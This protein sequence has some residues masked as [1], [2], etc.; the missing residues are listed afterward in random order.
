MG[1]TMRRRVAVAPARVLS[2][3]TDAFALVMLV[4]VLIVGIYALWDSH[5]VYSGASAAQWLPYRPIDG[6]TTSYD[7]L[8]GIN[9][10]V[11]GWLN[12]Y[13]T[14][15]DY[16]VCQSKTKALKYVTADAFGEYSMSGSL[17]VASHDDATFTKPRTII[18]GHHM[19]REMMFG[20][21]DNFMDE[22]YL[23]AHEHGQLFANGRDWGLVME[24]VIETEAHDQMIYGSYPEDVAEYGR[25]L[26]E[27]CAVARRDWDPGPNDRYVLMSTCSDETTEGRIVLVARLTNQKYINPFIKVPNY[28]TGVDDLMIGTFLGF[29]GNVWFCVAASTILSIVIFIDY[30]VIRRRKKRLAS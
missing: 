30:V 8:V 23:Y 10:E 12:V 5:Q 26:R 27:R 9:P 13:G 1:A 11:V 16:P 15:I 29:S 21:I 18:Y 7:Q 3:L 24:G 17:F 19:A 22:G 28:G 25:A 14:N 2:V 4:V 20:S 6:Q